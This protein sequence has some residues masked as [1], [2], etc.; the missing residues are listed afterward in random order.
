MNKI[1]AMTSN[2]RQSV[3][4][5]A[6]QKTGR[7]MA[8]QEPAPTLPRRRTWKR[9]L[10]LSVIVVTAPLWAPLMLCLAAGIKLVSRGPIF[11][12][13]ERVGQ[14]GQKFLCYKFRS[15]RHKTETASHQ[16]HF[17]DLVHSKAPMTK[18]DALGDPRLIPLGSILRAT[19]LDELP[20]IFNVV[21]GEMSLVGP[22]PCTPFEYETFYQPSDQRRFE[23]LPGLTGLWQVSGK[24]ET[25]FGQMIEL[26]I[27]YA[28]E[29]SLG[30]DLRIMF[31]TLP[32]M[33]KETT[34][35][36]KRRWKMK[37][38]AGKVPEAKP[39]SGSV[40]VNAKNQC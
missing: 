2:A 31:K 1:I 22:R 40:A 23:A 11:F 33:L 6:S 19:G 27:R 17:K 15:M 5:E 13:Q 4:W 25:T 3:C 29:Q 39:L 9:T 20:Q 8:P 38:K 30:L 7:P 16:A 12:R 10:D 14:R 21:R 32:V 35:L 28:R 34:R 26:D 24:N 36:L 37:S 18:L